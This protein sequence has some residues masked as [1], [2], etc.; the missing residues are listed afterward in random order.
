[1]IDHQHMN[2]GLN[3]VMNHGIGGGLGMGMGG[4]GMMNS[5]P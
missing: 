1:M 5:L 4:M 3:G 2:M